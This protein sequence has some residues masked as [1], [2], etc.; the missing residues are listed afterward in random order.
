MDID[1]IMRQV[2]QHAEAEVTERICSRVELEYCVEHG[3]FASIQA[4]RGGFEEGTQMQFEYNVCCE[5]LRA[6]VERAVREGEPN[7]DD[8]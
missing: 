7:G 1:K 5:N 4:V 2:K 3:Q 8:L 6:Q